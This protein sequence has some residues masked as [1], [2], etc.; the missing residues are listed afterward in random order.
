MSDTSK[1]VI[2]FLASDFVRVVLLVLFP[3]LIWGIVPEQSFGDCLIRNLNA[4]SFE[5]FFSW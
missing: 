4:I 5:W 2:P 1:G 3:V